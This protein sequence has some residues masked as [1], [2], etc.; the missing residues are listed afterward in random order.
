VT[1]TGIPAAGKPLAKGELAENLA[2]K[3]D[4]DSEDEV[5]PGG[6]EG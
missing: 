5:D 4:I 2:N 6:E 3:T 1:S